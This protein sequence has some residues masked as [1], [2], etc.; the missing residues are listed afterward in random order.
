MK[1]ETAF[2][3]PLAIVNSTTDYPT[4]EHATE[5]QE[6][7]TADENIPS[8]SQE[9]RRKPGVYIESIEYTRP[10]SQRYSKKELD[11]LAKENIKVTEIDSDKKSKNT[12]KIL[13]GENREE[14]IVDQF[15]HLKELDEL[16]LNE[17]CELTRLE[18]EKLGKFLR[19]APELKKI[20][21]ERINQKRVK[22]HEIMKRKNEK[23]LSIYLEKVL[24]RLLCEMEKANNWADKKVCQRVTRKIFHNKQ[25]KRVEPRINPTA[26]KEIA[27][28][29]KG[30]KT[31]FN[32]SQVLFS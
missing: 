32:C 9:P 10:S 4:K 24:R 15:L 26:M 27:Q 1:E 7:K 23:R 13:Q 29:I 14:K 19:N 3:I 2:T 28:C 25:E 20:L 31:E 12:E 17:N 16:N 21:L 22:F 30:L 18:K 8:T 5:D 6:I 11:A